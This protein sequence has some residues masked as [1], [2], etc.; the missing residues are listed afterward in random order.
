MIRPL[1]FA[2]LA[3][4]AP[5]AMAATVVFGEDTGVGALPANGNAAAAAATFA[6]GRGAGVETLEGLSGAANEAL[7]SFGTTGVTAT[8]TVDPSVQIGGP[9]T[10]QFATSGAQ[11]I[12]DLGF[13]LFFSFSTPVPGFG[14]FVSGLADDGSSVTATAFYVTGGRE[15]FL[16][17][18]AGAAGSVLFWGLLADTPSEALSG[19]LFTPAGGDLV[20]LDDLTVVSA[21]PLPAAA[22]ALITALTALGGI[23]LRRRQ[24]H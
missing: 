20:A 22:L 11:V 21:V 3:L 15:D 19:L 7:Y 14:T 2:A 9:G 24:G 10:G 1:L 23:G 5:S 17:P 16:L 18:A 6:A 13:G 4:L 8:A 12:A